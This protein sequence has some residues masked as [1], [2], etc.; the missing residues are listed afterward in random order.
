MENDEQESPNGWMSRG[1]ISASGHAL[2]E[3]PFDI[4]YAGG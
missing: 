4:L 2:Y 3:A 1:A